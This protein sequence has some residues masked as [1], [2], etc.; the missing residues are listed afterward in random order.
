M[1]P[2]SPKKTLALGRL[3]KRKPSDARAIQIANVEYAEA[4]NG[5]IE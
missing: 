4:D 5:N 1:L 3:R 2:T